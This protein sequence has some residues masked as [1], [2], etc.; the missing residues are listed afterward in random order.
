MSLKKKKFSNK[1]ILLIIILNV[2]FTAGVLYAFALTGNEPVV[3][4]GSWFAWTTVELACM[5]NIKLKKIKKE[6]VP[7]ENKLED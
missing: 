7:Y 6:G 2:V 4:V 1:A 3:L 5:M